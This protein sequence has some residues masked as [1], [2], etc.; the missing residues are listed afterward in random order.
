MIPI[1]YEL[2]LLLTGVLLL[3]VLLGVALHIHG[4]TWVARTMDRYL[5]PITAPMHTHYNVSYHGTHYGM[6]QLP[7][8]QCPCGMEGV[9]WEDM[10]HPPM[11]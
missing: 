2:I 5:V 8:D 10:T 7:A 9:A 6:L 11:G 3:G 1:T 4:G